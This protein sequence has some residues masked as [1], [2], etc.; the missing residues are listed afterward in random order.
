LQEI[1]IPDSVKHIDR[2]AFKNCDA[3]IQTENGVF[4]VNNWVVGFDNAV[5]DVV[6]R[7]NTVGIC[8]Y[9]FQSA[10]NLVRVTLPATVKYIGESAFS[11]INSLKEII[12][13]GTKEEWEAVEKGL[14]WMSS[15]NNAV[16]VFAKDANT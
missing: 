13:D 16:I 4:Y 2:D 14:Y 8:S 11:N 15:S 10:P 5:V 9:A 12:F 6:L 1:V 3:L 7:S